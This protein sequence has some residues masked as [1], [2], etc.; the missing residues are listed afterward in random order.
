M[1]ERKP[2]PIS[3]TNSPSWVADLQERIRLL[4][5]TP[6]GRYG[7][8]LAI[9]IASLLL[10]AWTFDPKLS[11]SGDNTEFIILAR[12]MAEGKGLTYI[13]APDLT[14]AT[15]YPFGFPLL[16][17]PLERL[18]PG[19]WVPMKWLV[20]VLLSLGMPIFYWL[21]RERLNVVPALAATIFCL[22]A[23]RTLQNS[24]P[25]LLDYGHQVMSEIPYMT[26]SLFALL[27]VE[28]GV[29]TPG[30]VRNYRFI[31]GFLI[32]MWA[33]YI[34]SIGLVL[35]AAVA[36]YL[37]VRRDW[38]RALAFSSAALLTW[39]PWHL[40]NRAVGGGS[41]YFRQLL[42]VNPYRPEQG[43]LDFSSLIERLFDNANFYLSFYLPVN[44]WPWTE[45]YPNVLNPLSPL[46]VVLMVYAAVLCLR[47][48]QDLLLF[49]YSAFY[50]GTVLVW[51]WIG[52][53]FL[54]PIVPMLAFFLV[55]LSLDAAARLERLKAGVVG[56]LLC[57][58][59]FFSILFGNINS[60][61]HL[62]GLGRGDYADYLSAWRNYQDAGEWLRENTSTGSIVVCRKGLWMYIVSGRRCIGFPF[63]APE[64][65]ISHMEREKVDFVV[66]ESL[67]FPQ[68]MRFL[69]PTIARYPERFLVLWQ[70]KDPPTHILRFLHE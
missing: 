17:A 33:C 34:R 49:I 5:E 15:K 16:L 44:L 41:S 6:V 19:Q 45:G 39:L 69:L 62:A 3:S 50:L 23:G 60:A 47:R 42:M 2:P 40:R 66:V 7:I 20:V 11:I 43:F 46:V 14:P 48:R 57:W 13:N 55:R 22:T 27:L 68:T 59:L 21:I 8:P 10:G 61:R 29:R 26:F 12:S 25:L 36:T 24:G 64:K 30:I 35:V 31:G 53:R 18:F 51:P 65:V 9:L 37:F 56:L 28:K 1:R 58:A 38:R 54:A 67:G 63:D 52:D 4:A 32:T 70:K